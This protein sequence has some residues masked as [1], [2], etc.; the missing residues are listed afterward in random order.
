MTVLVTGGA[1]FIGSHTVLELLSNGYDVV[2][3]DNLCNASRESLRRAEIRARKP[4][5]QITFASRARSNVLRDRAMTNVR[6]GGI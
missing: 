3:E 6:G 1:G 5:S 2:V 4:H